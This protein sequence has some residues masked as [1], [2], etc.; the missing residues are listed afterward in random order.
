[1]KKNNRV[2]S[3]KRAYGITE[4]QYDEMGE[5]QGWKCAIC[6]TE[7]PGGPGKKLMV[8]H[9]HKTGEIRGL[10]CNHCNSTIGYALE[11]PERLRRAIAYLEGGSYLRQTF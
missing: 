5:K 6:G 1:V 2:Q 9:N 7:K 8:D 10:L 4:K 11:C 3:L